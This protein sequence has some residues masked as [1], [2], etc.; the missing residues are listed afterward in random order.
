MRWAEEV[1]RIREEKCLW[2]SDE[3]ESKPEDQDVNG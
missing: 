3:K 2:D 1:A